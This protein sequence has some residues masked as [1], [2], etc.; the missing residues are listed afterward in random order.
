MGEKTGRLHA[1]RRLPSGGRGMGRSWQR[2]GS[3][4]FKS[5]VELL[6]CLD[7]GGDEGSSVKANGRGERR[8]ATGHNCPHAQ[9]A[10]TGHR[11]GGRTRRSGQREGRQSGGERT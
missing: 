7:T 4:L 1:H 10:S 5:G 3:R 6:V 8:R 2:R 9:V 11:V